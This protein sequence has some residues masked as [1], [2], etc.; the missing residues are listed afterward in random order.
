MDLPACMPVLDD[1]RLVARLDSHGFF[2]TLARDHPV[3]CTALVN[4]VPPDR[5][6]VT[7]Q[8]GG[9]VNEI[10]YF[11]LKKVTLINFDMSVLRV[12]RQQTRSFPEYG[13]NN[14]ILTGVILF[15]DLFTATRRI[16]CISI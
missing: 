10:W 6:M 3:P 15:L 12:N 8:P 2:A 14:Q 11:Q 1:A 5:L 16:M 4:F 13:E 9:K 7:R